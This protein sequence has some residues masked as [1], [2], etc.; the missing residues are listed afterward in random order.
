MKSLLTAALASF[1]TRIAAQEESIDLLDGRGIFTT[2]EEFEA[3]W[4]AVDESSTQYTF[5]V[6]DEVKV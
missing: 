2:Q 1:V 3:N 4:K 5:K 6:T